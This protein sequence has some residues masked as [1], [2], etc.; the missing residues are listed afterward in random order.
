MMKDLVNQSL[1]KETPSSSSSSSSKESQ[2]PTKVRPAE[3]GSSNE[4]TPAS[5]SSKDFNSSAPANGTYPFRSDGDNSTADNYEYESEQGGQHTSK[6]PVVVR[7]F[8]NGK[9]QIALKDAFPKLIRLNA[10]TE[11]KDLDVTELQPNTSRY[12]SMELQLNRQG[13]T[14]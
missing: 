7:K 1:A 3:P 11:A 5:T 2:A 10:Q 13:D 12:T 4:T 9:A 6:D 8:R 14:G